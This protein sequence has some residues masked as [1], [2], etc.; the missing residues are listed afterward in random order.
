MAILGSQ[1]RPNPEVFP[2][3]TSLAFPLRSLTELP[4]LASLYRDDPSVH[5]FPYDTLCGLN[6][7]LVGRIFN[8]TE[9]WLRGSLHSFS[10]SLRC[11]SLV[12]EYIHPS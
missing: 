6:G 7:P 8:G 1:A 2:D 3:D 11:F 9:F 4:F 10:V 12:T 5:S